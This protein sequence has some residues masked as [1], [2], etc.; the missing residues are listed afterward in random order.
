LHFH[1]L[2]PVAAHI[3]PTPTQMNTFTCL[4]C[5]KNISKLSA[6][7]HLTR[8]MYDTA[9]ANGDIVIC[10][11]PTCKGRNS[12]PETT[13]STPHSKHTSTSND[14]DIELLEPEQT[15]ATTPRSYNQLI[16]SVCFYCG[17][18]AEKKIKGILSLGKHREFNFC[19]TGE[20]KKQGHL[21]AKIIDQE[22]EHIKEDDS[23]L[24]QQSQII[25]DS[26]NNTPSSSQQPILKDQQC[27][28]YTD[29]MASACTAACTDHLSFTPR[30]SQ[31]AMYFCKG[32]HLIRYL[33][34]HHT[35]S[36]K[37]KNITKQ[38]QKQQNNNINKN[39]RNS[40]KDD[41]DTTSP[42]SSPLHH[43]PQPLS[44]PPPIQ[45]TLPSSQST[46]PSPQSTLPSSQSTPQ[47]T[48]SFPQ[49]VPSLREKSKRKRIPN[50]NN[51]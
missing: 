42:E 2:L 51:D 39:K 16:G 37:G 27:S 1:S 28:G 45:S 50:V 26:P 30:G 3:L 22:L 48:L 47:S 49:Q 46:L 6:Y 9:T 8:C 38:Q 35:G 7:T 19:Q 36:A 15:N 24:P 40:A 17:K 12:H 33:V 18:K 5:E 44:F 4:F 23:P 11:C 14:N 21:I 32:T 13:P 20:L 41:S 34:K 25:S 31:R 10:S 29:A 43:N